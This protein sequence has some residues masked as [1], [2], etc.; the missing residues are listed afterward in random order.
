M[1]RLSRAQLTPADVLTVCD[2]LMAGPFLWGPCDCCSAACAVF[3]RL[4]G[5]NPMASLPAY[6]GAQGAARVIA[7]AGGW[8]ALTA[9]LARAAGLSD[10]HAIGGL[11]LSRPDP[12]GRRSLMIC[13][14]H[15]L[16]AAKSQT[17]LAI[18]R[19]AAKGWHLAQEDFADHH[20]PDVG[21]GAHARAG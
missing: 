11:A 8:G 3:A 19:V 10:G 2:D 20:R 13:V 21:T 9:R 6:A 16:W 15:G 7:E 12:R 14:D 1:A 18:V 17:G 4:H 5:I